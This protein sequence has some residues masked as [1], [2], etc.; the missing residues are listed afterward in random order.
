MCFAFNLSTLFGF[1][2]NSHAFFLVIMA[3]FVEAEIFIIP[4]SKKN[5]TEQ[6]G[7]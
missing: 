2:W 7:V 4:L 1:A 3:G 6:F 5:F